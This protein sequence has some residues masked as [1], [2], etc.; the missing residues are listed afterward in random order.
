MSIL[1][2]SRPEIL[3]ANKDFLNILHI[4]QTY[5][6]GN[7]KNLEQRS[8]NIRSDKYRKNC[9]L[10]I[11]QNPIRAIGCLR[12]LLHYGWTDSLPVWLGI[13]NT[14]SVAEKK[15]P[16]KSSNN[17]INLFGIL[18]KRKDIDHCKTFLQ[19]L[20]MP[21]SLLTCRYGI[22]FNWCEQIR[23]LAMKICLDMTMIMMRMMTKAFEKREGEGGGSYHF[24]NKQLREENPLCRHF[25]MI[26]MIIMIFV[27]ITITI[28]SKMMW[29]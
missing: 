18:Q 5:T 24:T 2:Y 27:R 22:G 21:C 13:V 15:T 12:N 29:E 9:I 10:L 19:A 4:A 8:W 17:Q 23:M 14:F 1:G 6:T 7:S 28:I 11:S 25:I 3:K 26:N 16:P 20:S